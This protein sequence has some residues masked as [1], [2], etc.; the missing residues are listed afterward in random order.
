L[1]EF[2]LDLYYAFGSYVTHIDGWGTL[3]MAVTFFSYGEIIRTNEFGTTINTFHSF[4]GALSLSYGTRLTPNL[5]AG[6]TGKVIYSKLADQG[7]GQELGSGSA[8]AFAMDAGVLYNTPWRRLDLG[9]AL[10]N[11]GP[12]I[13]YIDAQQSDPLPRNLAVGM[14]LRLADS[15]FNK[16]MIVADVNKELVDL[17]DPTSEF[18]QI[19]YNVGAEWSY[20]G[21]IAGRIGYVYD[22]DGS[23]KVL[24]LGV[25]LAYSGGRADVAYIPSTGDT[26]LA[27]TLRWSITAR[28]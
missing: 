10:T 5:G 8:T 18:K 12:N 15:P 9:A 23:I 26:P 21:L 1:P 28:F 19:I 27:N 20:T 2:N 13:S 25:G 16:L 6:L 22:Q 3:G 7:A 14:A 17:N 24:T 11:V 4:D